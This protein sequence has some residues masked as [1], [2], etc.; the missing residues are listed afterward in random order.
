MSP[1]EIRQRIEQHIPGATA[2]VR[3]YTGT[4]DHFEVRVVASAFE[5][6]PLIERHQMIYAALGAAVDG[7]TIH[8]LSLKTLTPAQ[9][10]KA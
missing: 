2:E 1:Q 8:A 9:A 4:G 5:G 10:A 3:D 6:K 7:R